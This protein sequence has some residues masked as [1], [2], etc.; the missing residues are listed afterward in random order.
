MSRLV[1]IWVLG[2]LL[3]ITGPA[4]TRVERRQ[5]TDEDAKA[6]SLAIQDEVY[7]REYQKRFY[8]VG[9]EISHDV[10]SLPVYINPILKD[11]GSTLIYKLMPY[12]EVIRGFHFSKDGFVVLEGDPDG[13]FPPTDPDMLTLYLDDEDLCRWKHSWKKYHFEIADSPSAVRIAEAGTRQK[14]R[15]GYSYREMPSKEQ[16][17]F[18]PQ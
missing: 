6:I 3:G 5:I 15:V 1:P 14:Q 10:T 2:L 16:R 17:K 13:G 11:G 12:G 18:P 8:M 7:D 9:P 4:Q